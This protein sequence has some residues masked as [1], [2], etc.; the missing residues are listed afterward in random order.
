MNKLLTAEVIQLYQFQRL[1]SYE[2]A[3]RM[4]ERGLATTPE[5]IRNILKRAKVPLRSI[6]EA[7][8]LLVSK[9]WTQEMDDGLRRLWPTGMSGP[10]IVDELRL[11]VTARAVYMRAGVLKLPKR[12]RPAC[13]N[14]E[15]IRKNELRRRHYRERTYAETMS[16]A[17]AT[18]AAAQYVDRTI[19]RFTPESP[20]LE[21][22]WRNVLAAVRAERG[23][24]WTEMVTH[25]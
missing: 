14:P 2:V 3:N 10:Q 8:R 17:T 25:R 15:Q 18:T 7:R 6:K 12:V 23:A 20:R 9:V 21:L 5:T 1:S 11:P 24:Q 4:T 22:E 16:L 19:I 13:T